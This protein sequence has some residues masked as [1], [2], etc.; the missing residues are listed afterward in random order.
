MNK[1][2][3]AILMGS[4]RPYRNGEAVAQWVLAQARER[5]DAHFDLIDLKQVD[6]PFL[7][8]PLPPSLG[9]YEHEHT[10]QWS[11]T[12]AGYD[13]FVLVTPEYN[14]GTS[15]VLKNA[16]DTV[17]KEWN[18]KVAGFVA[19][20]SMGGARAVEQLRL[21][22][23]ELQVAT[24][25]AQVGL[26]LSSDF[27]NMREFAPLP[28]RTAELTTMLDQLLAWGNALR[29]VREK[30]DAASTGAEKRGEQPTLGV[31]YK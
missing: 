24:V 6:L 28:Q 25:R 4:T 10:R 30:A 29:T 11:R 18:N 16:L 23:A 15:A 14:H 31:V 26:M 19:Y 8:E 21:N 9:K 20:G 3:I 2:N 17:Y 1:L 7:D 13:G 22:M 12:V 5:N 27:K